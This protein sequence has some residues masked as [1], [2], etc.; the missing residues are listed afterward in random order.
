MLSDHIETCCELLCLRPTKRRKSAFDFVHKFPPGVVEDED[1]QII[2]Y[3]PS[4]DE[5][6]LHQDVMNNIKGFL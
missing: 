1:G 5:I 2:E 3:E 4:Y 6:A